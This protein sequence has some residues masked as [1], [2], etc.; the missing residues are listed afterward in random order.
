MQIEFAAKVDE[1]SQQIVQLQEENE[2]YQSLT[3]G[4][5]IESFHE[6]DQE[7]HSSIKYQL[8]GHNDH[9]AQLQKQGNK[10]DSGLQSMQMS[11]LRFTQ[12]LQLSSI[13]QVELACNL[14]ATCL[15]CTCGI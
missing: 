5:S 2:R 8:Q 14:H 10:L 1:L 4:A 12:M 13:K 15:V 3:T 6:D 9:P 11:E 7:F